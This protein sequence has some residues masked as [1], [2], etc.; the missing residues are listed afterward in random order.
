[1]MKQILLALLL[2]AGSAARAQSPAWTFAQPIADLNGVMDVA[3]DASGYVYLTGRLVGTLQLGAT[4]ISSSGAGTG[5]YIAKCT[6]RGEVLRVTKLEG[7]TDALPWSIAVDNAGNTYVT[8]QFKGMLSYNKGRQTA[9]QLSPSGNDIFTLKCG[10]TG[11][12]QWISQARGSTS[13]VYGAS[14]GKAVAVDP[15]GNSYV[16]GVV[17]GADVRFGTFAFGA[18][19]NQAFLASYTP[20]GALRWAKVWAEA[21]PGSHSSCQGGDVA[22]DKNG[23]CYV[24]GTSAGNWTLGGTTVQTPYFSQFLAKFDTQQGLLTWGQAVPGDGDG[25]A[26]ALDSHGHAYVGGSFSGT[27][28]FGS[29]SLACSG[30]ADGFVAHYTPQGAI[31]WATAVGGP[32][33]DGISDLAINQKSDKIFVTGLM[34]FTPQGTNQTHLCQL[35]SAGQVQQVQLVGGPGTSSGGTL[36]VD[37]VNNLYATGVFTGSCGFGKIHLAST[38]TQGYFARYGMRVTGHYETDPGTAISLY[39]NPVQGQFTLRLTNA[40]QAVQATLYNAQGRAVA[41]HSLP[42]AADAS[43][44]SAAFDTSALPNGFYTLRLEGTSQTTSRTVC[45]QH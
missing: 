37:E 16:T 30:D 38:A 3:T 33:Y 19:N 35:S 17:S 18:R 25:R 20:L 21:T 6:A 43:D 22:V 23:H 32:S 15:A 28:A 29:T 40:T 44:S 45:V 12:V 39:P 42:L 36:A 7:A 24:S 14:Y 27:V 11:A 9:T 34:N 31:A 4:Q 5:I 1:M 41:M 8:G 13:E 2:V 26:L 10:P